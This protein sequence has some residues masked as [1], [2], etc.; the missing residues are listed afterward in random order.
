MT[1]SERNQKILDVI[2]KE[3][4]KALASKKTA[5]E[6]LIK[7]GIYTTKGEL[8]VEFGG[9]RKKGGAAA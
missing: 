4:A 7:E 3:T 5:R 9:R 8:R 1:H 2:A 6:T